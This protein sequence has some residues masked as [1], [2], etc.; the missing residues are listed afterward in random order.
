MLRFHFDVWSGWNWFI[1]FPGPPRRAHFLEA[2]KVGTKHAVLAMRLTNAGH[3]WSL[4]HPR[5]E[6]WF[7]T[8]LAFCWWF[9]WPGKMDGRY[10]KL[11]AFRCFQDIF[12]IPM[13]AFEWRPHREFQHFSLA[14][15]F[16][17]HQLSGWQTLLPC[18]SWARGLL[19]LTAVTVCIRLPCLGYGVLPLAI[20]LRLDKYGLLDH[21][22]SDQLLPWSWPRSQSDRKMA[23]GLSPILEC[24]C[25][26]YVNT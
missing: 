10:G 15:S 2:Q 4:I 16:W 19:L 22:F 5:E 25:F 21:R 1:T 12:A 8:S 17:C 24:S 14:R 26:K 23:V 9:G 6:E 3:I 11:P 20:W 18:T 13:N 7:G